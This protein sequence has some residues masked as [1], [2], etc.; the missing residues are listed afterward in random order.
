MLH[1]SSS[2]P[3]TRSFLL[4]PCSGLVVIDNVISGASKVL[5]KLLAYFLSIISRTSSTKS[6]SR[7]C[8]RVAEAPG[9]LTHIFRCT[10]A[11]I[12]WMPGLNTSFDEPVGSRAL[13][14]LGRAL[15]LNGESSSVFTIF[16]FALSTRLGRRIGPSMC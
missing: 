11:L 8:T 15:C 12:S 16:A 5:P 6:S 14:P 9:R 4:S 3:S 1:I 13:S 2:G 7:I 10:I